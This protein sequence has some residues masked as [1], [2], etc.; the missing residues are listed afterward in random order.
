MTSHADG[1][2]LSDVGPRAPWASTEVE[3]AVADAAGDAS[4]LVQV[5]VGLLAG[6]VAFDGLGLFVH[7]P[8]DRNLRAVVARVDGIEV[9]APPDWV[10]V[11]ES[12]LGRAL[13]TGLPVRVSLDPEVVHRTSRPG[14]RPLVADAV[15]Q[16]LVIP[17]AV[18][19][20]PVGVVCLNRRDP[21]APFGPEDEA[22]VGAA[23]D[24]L[25]LAFDHARMRAS[26]GQ[27]FRLSD[28][29]TRL[30]EAAL[31]HRP[32]AEF[33][34]L[35]VRE[36]AYAIQ[37]DVV[38]IF[39]VEPGGEHAVH[40]VTN[41]PA[42]PRRERRVTI[43]RTP[44]AA[45]VDHGRQVI[46]VD[47]G[48]A[49]GALLP[50]MP[51]ATVQRAAS[52]ALRRSGQTVGLL[53]IGR[54]SREGFTH[55]E[56]RFLRSLAHL[57]SAVLE[58]AAA[59]ERL[60]LQ[61]HTDTLTGLANRELLTVRAAEAIARARETGGSVALLLADLDGFKL[62][63]DSM[64][65]REGD[66]LLRSVAARLARG[67]RPTDLVA[68]VGG[69]EFAVLCHD[70]DELAATRIAERLLHELVEAVSVARAR[71]TVRAS[72]G[73]AEHRADHARAGDDD[74]VDGL[75]QRADLAMYRAKA[76]GGN[77]VAVYDVAVH[78]ESTR[79][80]KIEQGV[81]HAL[82]HDGLHLV[83]QPVVALQTGEVRGAEA[84]V[85]W[86]HPELGPVGPDEFVA[87]AE[88]SGLVAELDLWVLERAAREAMAWLRQGLFDGR[89]LGVNVSGRSLSTLDFVER[90]RAVLAA[91]GLPPRN[92]AVEVTE[93]H[94]TDHTGTRAL[95]QLH[96]LG[97]ACCVDDFGTGFASIL[98]LKRLPLR[99]L[100]IDRSF[101]SGLGTDARDD[102]IIQATVHLA[103][104]LGLSVI[105]E[106]V[107]TPEQLQALTAVGCRSA[108]GYLLSRPIP[109]RDLAALLRAGPLD[110][111]ALASSPAA[112]PQVTL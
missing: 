112:D 57:V 72:I 107:E 69:D 97:I 81:A 93:S 65:H 80:L 9:P 59:H 12:H 55:G 32:P 10:P 20:T 68:R 56:Q 13:L 73:V 100:K 88:Q 8:A 58:R 15:A 61:A 82:R 99:Y 25:A 43:A 103:A 67:V 48:D 22:T 105:A 41:E 33:Q 42:D 51:D 87:V 70:A 108:Q 79:R 38:S 24:R 77:R 28:A 85:R 74:A 110:L 14:F 106:G 63:N 29:L 78:D 104:Q 60:W 47:R 1:G 2:P 6:R 44:L 4:A 39:E 89:S 83:F 49:D 21:D 94:L 18:A 101:T 36:V 3:L 54:R 53:A 37:A 98:Q 7:H 96:D 45:H 31:G 75:L 11:D 19:G 50:T 90:F 26:A 71:V 109:A 66:N 46:V 92:L 35:V 111:A 102:A 16:L 86:T 30:G 64:G 27:Q 76:L 62:V 17:L 34:R 5:L 95:Q 52:V 84:L 91:S 40:A 23:A